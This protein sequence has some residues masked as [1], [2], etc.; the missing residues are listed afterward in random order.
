MARKKTTDVLVAEVATAETLEEMPA[1]PRNETGVG[2]PPEPA[3]SEPKPESNG[4]SAARNRPAVSWTLNSDRTTRIEVSAW[5]N[6]YT[7]A[8]GEEYEQVSFTICRSYRDSERWHKG[9]SW[10]A[11]D[12]PCLIFL[13]QHKAHAWALERRTSVNSTPF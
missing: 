13:L 8:Q 2:T 5:I 11:H 7:N 6:H 4:E 9:G 12:I 1:V 3:L 10:R